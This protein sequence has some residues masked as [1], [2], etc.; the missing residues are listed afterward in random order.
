MR[1]LIADPPTGDEMRLRRW[2]TQP[3]GERSGAILSPCGRYRYALWR[4]LWTP[5]T[6]E[7]RSNY[8]LAWVMLNPSTADAALD[9]PTIRRCMSF[10]RQ[11]GFRRMV[12]FNLFGLRATNP[13]ELL[14]AADPEG[15]DLRRYLQHI[16]LCSSVMVAW[17]AHS[18]ARD[19][20]AR[21]ADL[22]AAK[23]L[24]CLRETKH[25]APGHPLY[26]PGDTDAILWSRYLELYHA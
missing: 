12:V 21:V 5:W 15:P 25:G 2:L 13:D 8:S 10:S 24:N 7:E 17:G 14:R 11:W 20:Y 19:Q 26:I 22:L 1:D 16:C 4:A 18:L 23:Q 6:E 9:D 3:Y